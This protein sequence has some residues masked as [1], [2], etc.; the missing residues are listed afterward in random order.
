MSDAGFARLPGPAGTPDDGP[1]LQRLVREAAAAF[2]R[3]GYD[4]VP[5]EAISEAAGVAKGTVYRHFASKNQL[6]MAAAEWAAADAL[7]SFVAATEGRQL[8]EAEAVAVLS[9]IVS[10][11]MGLVLEFATRALQEH[12]DHA[13]AM[14]RLV[15]DLSGE[16]ARCLPGPADQAAARG[17]R[18]LETALA[19]AYRRRLDAA[20]AADDDAAGA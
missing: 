9:D 3:W 13:L 2:S 19:E 18:L 7:R 1:A 6:F 5:V 20:L 16:F 14:R 12:P 4:A 15:D 8:T 10:D 17:R 11:G